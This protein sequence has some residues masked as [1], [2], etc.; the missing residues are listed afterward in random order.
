MYWLGPNPDSQ[1]L[2]FLAAFQSACLLSF[3]AMT[4]PDAVPDEIFRVPVRWFY[5]GVHA[6]SHFLFLRDD[7]QLLLAGVFGVYPAAP[8]G[9][10]RRGAR[11]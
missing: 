4:K 8:T 3:G 7:L 11:P 5:S 9:A 2:C 10:W 6:D 1:L